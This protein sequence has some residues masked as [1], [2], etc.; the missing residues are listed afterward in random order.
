MPRLT[1]WRLLRSG[2]PTPLREVDRFAAERGLDARDR[3]FVR[4]LVGTEIRRRA[5]LRAIVRE[6]AY[7]KPS[8]DFTAHLH[9]AIV[10][11]LFL[12][13]IPDHALS[14]ETMRLVEETCPPA[15][16]RNAR[17]IL[18]ALLLSR[19][20]G[21]TGNP[22]RD[23]VGR[24]LAL[25]RDVFA[26][27]VQHPALWA[28]EAL[29]M[30]APLFKGWT[31]RHGEERALALA[32]A[33]LEEPDLSLR[34]IGAER[35]AAQRELAALGVVARASR[36]PRLLLVDSAAADRALDSAAMREGRVTVQGESAL[37][38]AEAV[39]ATAGDSLLDL[40]AAPGGKTAVL[41]ESGARVLACDVD[42]RRLERLRDTLAR[43]GLAGRVETRVSDGAAELG[44]ATFDGVLIDAPCTN[45]GVLAQRP[46]ARWR[47]GPKF[48]AELVALQAR[49]MREG[50]ARV[51][52]GG[53]LVWSTCSLDPDE[54]ARQVR[55]FLAESDAWGLEEEALS[56]PDVGLADVGLEPTSST[57]AALPVSTPEIAADAAND[58]APAR[59]TLG[60]RELVLQKGDGPIDGGYFA[61]LRRYR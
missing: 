27:P 28:E 48:K 12:D 41:A 4:R 20:R 38:A 56:L 50:A 5:T 37:R 17:G 9:L 7:G 34:V 1:A 22:R 59:P 53:R 15:D 46:E 14:S 32:L 61:R 35:E 44:T 19:T 54:N 52:V 33:A 24:P 23:I 16:V 55:A 47:F 36:H 25:D 11:A 42:E 57:P 21:H 49:L 3:G 13:R 30:P 8:P 40:C 45:T 10:Q 58:P 43:L 39:Q 29:S 18:H 26:D 6:Y 60:A 31:T 2:S 51:K